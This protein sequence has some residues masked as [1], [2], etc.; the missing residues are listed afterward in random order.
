ML[1]VEDVLRSSAWYREVLGLVG[2]H[3]G[4]EFEMLMSDTGEMQ[5]MLHHRDFAEHPG[6]ADP[7]EGTPGR[8]VLLYFSVS[9]LTPVFER[10]RASGAD[11]VDEPHPNPKAG[12]I[13][14][15]LRDPDGY[16][17]SVSEWQGATKEV[18]PA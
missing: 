13:E 6:I 4:G 5:L 15:T 7:S 8:G 17:L 16:V 3:G 10:A 12:S 11:L 14:F 18:D 1:V 9:E 2:A